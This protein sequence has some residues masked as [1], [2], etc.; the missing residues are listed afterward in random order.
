VNSRVVA[1]AIVLNADRQVLLLRRSGT[2]TRR[3][4]DWDF[5][6]GRVDPGEDITEAAAREILEEAGI[7]V[8]P[9]ELTV[10]YAATEPWEPE[11]LSLTRLLFVTRTAEHDVR[12]SNEHDEFK[13]V[14]I[15]TALKEFPHPFYSVGLQYAVDH[16][17]LPE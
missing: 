9:T 13:W 12:L 7:A 15:K 2:D 8:A 16:Q 10:L 17:L 3:P 14:D 1:K 5:P 11:N 6:G 4:G